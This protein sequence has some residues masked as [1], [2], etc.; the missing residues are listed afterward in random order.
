MGE[1]ADDVLA[2]T[3]ITDAERNDYATVINKF[4]GFFKV[5]RNLIFERAKFNRRDQAEGESAEQYITC[6]YHLV[7][8]CE[9]GPLKEELLRDRIVVGIRDK[10]LSEKLQMDAALTLE[11][12]KTSIRQKEAIA[13]QGQTLQGGKKSS[14]VDSARQ[15]P[16]QQRH[17]QVKSDFQSVNQSDNHSKHPNKGGARGFHRANQQSKP[18]MRCGK[19]RHQTPDRCP[20]LSVTCHKCHR[21]GHY[22]S[23]CLSKTVAAT[24]QAE[25]CSDTEEEVFLGAVRSDKGSVWFT[26][27]SLQG[28]KVQFKMDTGAEVTVISE[29]AYHTLSTGK[30]Q[31]ASRN[32]FGPTHQ[33]L[34]IMGQFDGILQRGKLSYTEK[35]YV[36]K[37]L[38]N[39]LLGL[40]AIDALQLI[41]RVDS[42]VKVQMC[43]A[44]LSIRE[45]FPK[46]FK[47]LD[48][49]GEN[50]TIQMKEDIHP[51]ALYTP[52][53]VPFSLRKAVEEE[54]QRMESLGVI[55]K[56]NEPTPWC[57]G[58][59]VVPKKK[60]VR[61]CVDLKSLNESVLREVHPI[62]RV[63][64][65]LAQISGAKFFS[66]LDANSGFWQLITPY[67]RYC[68]NKLPF[69]ISSAPEIFQKRMN[70]ILEGLEGQT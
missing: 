24:T 50:Y 69:G 28:K 27:L 51:H 42:T 53:R 22:A 5:R 63:D 66:K 38:H 56:V 65:I 23:Q 3:N 13:A 48:T 16:R 4:D 37:N 46:V 54:L 9:Y 17:R 36:V 49:F 44:A 70:L 45:R 12:A 8:N 52:R 1:D 47:G 33:P 35:I 58:M 2:S 6:L 11:K 10:S 30:L 55:S 64:E 57:A 39:N 62:P 25:E 7:E 29:K 31:K 19:P 21:Q 18:C 20:A 15:V 34:A 40:P 60:G 59:V 61:I 26:N 43:E 41:K 32:L 14:S 67:G 68:F